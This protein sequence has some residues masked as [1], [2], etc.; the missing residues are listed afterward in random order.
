M[1]RLT[2]FVF[3]MIISATVSSTSAFALDDGLYRVKSIKGQCAQVSNE[4]LMTTTLYVEAE[5]P[6]S[7]SVAGQGSATAEN[8]AKISSLKTKVI[9]RGPSNSAE[10]SIWKTKTTQINLSFDQGGCVGI[11]MTMVP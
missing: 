2:S 5:K 3:G 4:T 11:Q 9:F 1:L 6:L 8:P 7:I 10:I